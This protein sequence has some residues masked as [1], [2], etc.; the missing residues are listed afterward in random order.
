MSK[1]AIIGLAALNLAFYGARSITAGVMVNDTFNGD[2]NVLE[3]SA[4]TPTLVQTTLIVSM[5]G[6][7]SAFAGFLH[8]AEWTSASRLVGVG[9]GVIACML[10]L[11]AMGFAGKQWELGARGD[12]DLSGR[13]Q[14]IGSAAVIQVVTQIAYVASIYKTPV[15]QDTEDGKNTIDAEIPLEKE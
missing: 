2:T 8:F 1:S 7:A 14:F 13:A 11:L 3:E 12:G 6:C 5:I 10:D 9:V 15:E 4:I